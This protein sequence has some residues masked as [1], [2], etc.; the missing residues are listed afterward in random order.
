MLT[1]EF[2]GTKE[3]LLRLLRDLPHA[4]AGR[5]STAR[6]AEIA[7]QVAEVV[8]VEALSIV[9]EAYVAKSRHGADEAGL[10]W[11]PLSPYTVAYKRRHP[12]LAAR[13]KYA[14]KAGR[15]RRPLLSAAQ[16][17][18]WR[19]IFAA[20]VARSKKPPAEAARIAWAAVKAMGGK[21]VLEEY[22][23]SPH[24]IGRDTGRLLASLGP[25][26]PEAVLKARPG[27]FFVGTNV[28]YARDF[29]RRRP[30]FPPVW[31]QP[32]KKRLAQAVIDA[33]TASLAQGRA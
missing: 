30:I 11:Q 18:A 26:S 9:K 21:T 6:G 14:A 25:E 13:R 8:G 10:S 23:S 16:D 28:E 31:A 22:G 2:S 32:W 4:M 29:A 27:S 33:L 7:R 3:D 24:E 17:R 19:R 1:V 5:A 20:A 12:K 15:V